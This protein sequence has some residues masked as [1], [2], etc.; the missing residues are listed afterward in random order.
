M[1]RRAAPTLSLT[2]LALLSSAPALAQSPAPPPPPPAT[3]PPEIVVAG[4]GQVHTR[5]DRA[6]LDVAVESRA[7]TAAGA[8]ADNARR[9]RAVLDTLRRLGY[10]STTLAT[11][12]YALQPDWRSDGGGREPKQVGYVAL[13]SVRVRVEQLDRLG[14]TID[15][16]LAAGA[17][18]IASLQF[19][20]ST[21][22]ELQLLALDSAVA[23]ARRRAATMARA[24]GGSLGP[25]VYLTTERSEPQPGVYPMTLQA[26]R[27][28][29]AAETPINAGE[30]TVATVVIGRWRFVPATGP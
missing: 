6:T 27:V 11:V 14:A 28:T 10:D 19:T 2:L 23:Q 5:P 13:N 20:A 7:R 25:L 29:S 16:A 15:A 17:N 12:G 24:A 3:A 4:T 18:R 9:L 26:V 1:P 21:E 8:G 30:M 22:A